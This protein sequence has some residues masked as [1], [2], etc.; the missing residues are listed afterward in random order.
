MCLF[1]LQSLSL[2]L[3]MEYST[4]TNIQPPTLIPRGSG[5]EGLQYE[6]KRVDYGI[7][8]EPTKD[9]TRKIKDRLKQLPDGE[10]WSI[11]Q[12]EG[13]YIREKPLLSSIELKKTRSNH[14][15]LL[16]IA[17]WNSALFQR[18]EGLLDWT[19]KGDEMLPV[20]SVTVSGHT[21]QVCYSYIEKDS[22]S[23][24]SG[25]IVLGFLSAG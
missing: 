23:R 6:G 7:F 2:L 18:L 13:F 12:T 17:I 1:P 11:N 21:W 22:C 4:S 25:S 5:V 9:E 15:P 16:Q 24:V 3:L 19:Y 8:I 14:D 10:V 20:P